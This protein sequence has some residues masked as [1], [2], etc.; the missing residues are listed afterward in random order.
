MADIAKVVHHAHQRGLIHRDLKPSNILLDAEDRPYVTD[1]GLA[2]RVQEESSLTETGA[3][4]GTPA[5]MA[6]EQTTGQ[7]ATVTTLADLYSL[8]GILYRLIAGRQPFKGDTPMETLAQIVERPPIPPQI[9]N[10]KIDLDLSTI[11]LKCI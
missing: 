7:H 1:F 8:G 2:K 11:C 9:H 4:L 3:V 5:Y 10:P 6:P